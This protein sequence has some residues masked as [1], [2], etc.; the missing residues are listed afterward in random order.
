MHPDIRKFWED[1][2]YHVGIPS[3]LTQISEGWK[4]TDEDSWIRLLVTCSHGKSYLFNKKW[5]SEKDMLK[6]IKLKVFL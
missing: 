2:G 1:A 4:R 5:Y 6:I 3:A